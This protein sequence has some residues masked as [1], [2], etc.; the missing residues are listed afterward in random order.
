VKQILRLFFIIITALLLNLHS[1]S[2]V[3]A[4]QTYTDA[5]EVC[6]GQCTAFKFVW[7]GDFCYDTFQNEC[8]MGKGN[9]IKE[10]IKFLKG[11]YKVLKDGTGVDTAFKAWFVCKPL[12]EQCI[13]PQLQS[14]RNTCST[15]TL[16]YAPDL[17]VGNPYAD[18]IY[19]GVIYNDDYHTLTFK[20]VNNGRGYAWDIGA[21]ASWGHT[22]NRD[23]M[24]SGGGQLFKET[25][26][27]MIYFGARNGPPKT[28]G[29][30]VTD[31]LIE[32]TNFAKYL[33][34]F[35]SDA[36]NYNVPIIWLKTIPFTAPEGELTKVIFN[37]DPNQM[38]TEYS[39][40]NNTFILTIDKLPTPPSFEIED[41]NQ[42]L[43]INTLN[44]FLIDFDIKNNGQEN[45]QAIVKIFEGKYN[46]TNTQNPIYE[47]H[48]VVEGL[49]K[50]GFSTYI[51]PDITQSE[52]YCGKTKKYELVVFDDNGK[53]DSHEFSLPLYSGSVRGRVEDLFGKNIEGAT[54]TATSGQTT[55]TGKTGSYYLHGINMLGNVTIT[56]T[57]PQFS[58]VE[59]KVLDFKINNINDPCEEDSLT[60]NN[61]NF[62]L[63]DQDVMFTITI[64]DGAGYLVPAHVLASNQDWRFEQNITDELTPMPGMQPGKYVFTISAPGYKTISQ[65]VNA[66]PNNQN[67]EFTLEKLNGRPTDGGLTILTQPQLLWQ[68]DR[69]TEI[70]AN[71]TATKDG[72]EVMLYTVQ[73]KANTGK[74]YFLEAQTGNQVKVI[75][76]TY[77]TSGNSQACLD[78]SYDGD[79]TALYVHNGTA[80]MAQNTRNVLKLFNNQGNEIGTTDFKSGG[81]A[82]ECD[83]SP[84]GFYIYPNKLM[85]K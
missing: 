46:D 57:H 3:H 58:K 28:V 78:T 23:G 41:F 61:I 49:N 79:T 45:G 24:V 70:L 10:T 80:G 2:P 83:V 75:S 36:D 82:H 12:I 32:E 59:T 48:H 71:I 7:Q 56:A 33:Q 76:G 47:N 9:T 73:N 66:V 4:A 22:R 17:S 21:E 34:D 64:K 44:N 27:E 29:D 40:L 18:F 55:T 16:Y 60:F 84:D 50:F 1:I 77:A 54:I 14:C 30:Y 52:D 6:Y 81:G 51:A 13:V 35:K 37:V 69:G 65:D 19:H 68:M 5:E 25:I 15:D 63:K 39:E 8:V 20:V 74:L 72:K 62:V 38:I 31:F 53:V 85:N 43:E 67:L 11:I 26:P 42:N